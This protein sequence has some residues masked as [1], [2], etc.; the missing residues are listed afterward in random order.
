MALMI[1]L[2]KPYADI[3][4]AGLAFDNFAPNGQ[5]QLS[6]DPRG[7]DMSPID[8]YQTFVHY[9][10]N[11]LRYIDLSQKFNRVTHGSIYPFLLAAYQGETETIAKFIGQV[12]RQ[13]VSEKLNHDIYD[14]WSAANQIRVAYRSNTLTMT[15]FSKS[16][17][18]EDLVKQLYAF[19][20]KEKQ[21]DHLV[22]LMRL[23]PR[24]SAGGVPP[25]ATLVSVLLL[26]AGYVGT[27]EDAPQVH[28]YV[29]TST[30]DLTPEQRAALTPVSS[31]KVPFSSFGPV[32]A[33]DT[34]PEDEF[35]AGKVT[36]SEPALRILRKF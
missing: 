28:F 31:D 30:D 27:A 23:L 26:E 34:I 9:V 4:Y 15:T 32:G 12:N 25:Y 7:T 11:R 6:P 5:L 20:I 3:Y 2:C 1:A 21:L 18:N 24:T 19:M 10:G 17:V 35:T 29:R 8:I 13:S 33:E 16:V 22:D 36:H 14:P